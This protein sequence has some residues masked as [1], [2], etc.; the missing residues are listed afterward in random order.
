MK[1]GRLIGMALMALGFLITMLVGFLLAVQSDTNISGQ[2]LLAA[3]A[4]FLLVIAPVTGA[5]IYFYVRH[6]DSEEDAS[7]IVEKQRQLMDLLRA[8]GQI[9]VS[10]AAAQLNVTPDELVD[11]VV[12][13][14]ALEVFQGV[15]D[16]DAGMLYAAKPPIVG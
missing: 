8:N 15:A 14:E 3:L 9:S 5:G 1:Q 16:W 13:L 10:A 2:S 11:I 12:Q 7:S 4:I 6:A